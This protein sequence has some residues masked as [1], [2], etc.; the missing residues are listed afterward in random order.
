MLQIKKTNEKEKNFFTE[1][2]YYFSRKEIIKEMDC[3]IYSND[4]MNWYI[5]Y[6]NDK[7]VGFISVQEFE[8]YYYIDNFYIVDKYRSLGYGKELFEKVFKDII[9]EGKLIKLIT[10]NEYAKNI[11]EDFGII[12]VGKNG[13]YYKMQ[14]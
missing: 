9:F 1:M 7:I 8:R 2:G 10:S 14:I 12:T 13:K 4:K 5:A 11:F 6:I 3:Q